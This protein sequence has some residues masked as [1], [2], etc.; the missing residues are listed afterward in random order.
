MDK[1][2]QLQSLR[3]EINEINK[4]ILYLLNNRASIA[5]EVAKCKAQ[6]GISGFDPVREA[7][8]LSELF[9]ENEGPFSNEELREIFKNIFQKTLLLMDRQDRQEKLLSKKLGERVPLTVNGVE[10]SSDGGRMLVVAGP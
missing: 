4:K 3:S 1:K 9:E 8:M 10:I 5:L 6:L 7:E 2:E